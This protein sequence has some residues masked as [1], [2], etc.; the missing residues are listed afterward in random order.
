VLGMR[1]AEIRRKFDE[2]VAF[3][4]VERF[5]DTPLKHYS[6]GMQMR[7]AFAVAAHL[8]PEILFVDEVL[9]VGDAAFQKKCL[10]KM[11]D[12]A[13]QGR[14]ILFVSHNMTAINSLSSRCVL[15]EHGKITFNG[16]TATATTR[17]YAESIK[18][19]ANGA[20]LLQRPR[21]EG[22]GKARFSSITIQ[23]VN[24][25]GEELD[26]AYPGCDLEIETIL[27][28]ARSFSDCNL[29]IIFYDS[30]G[31]RIID[32]NTGQKGQFISLRAGEKGR[33]RFFLR[34]VL[35]KPGTYFVGLWLGRD[36]IEAVDYIEQAVTLDVVES[37]E[38]S[39]HSVAYPG[40]YLCRFEN[41]FTIG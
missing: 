39:R 3:S 25:E 40:V 34:E 30:N 26:A 20:D 7:L 12:V 37:E 4:E 2:I 32:T 10:G 33:S 23:P 36:G 8:E 13:R 11:S 38:S 19:G 21:A 17:Y 22:N 27:E 41:S 14:T 1:A 9:A 15:L 24:G 6:S 18:I 5:L 16:P 35:L 31:Y 28:C 29:A